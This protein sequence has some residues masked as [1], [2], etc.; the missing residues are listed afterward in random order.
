M[1]AP[2]LAEVENALEVMKWTSLIERPFINPTTTEQSYVGV[3][4]F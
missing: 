4:S 3:I 2:K 1:F